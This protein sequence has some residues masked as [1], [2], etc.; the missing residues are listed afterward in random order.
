MRP[1]VNTHL[2]AVAAACTLWGGSLV[3]T[4]LAFDSLSPMA[5]GLIRFSLSTLLFFIILAAR[6]E[7]KVP[8]AAD[9]GLMALT[10]FLGTTLY[11]AAENFG[12][13]ITSAGTASLVVGSFPAM[14]LVLE[15]AVDKKLPRPS[16]AL[17]MG[18]A[19]LGVA[20]LAL[21]GGSVSGGDEAP[22]I[23][24]LMAGGAAWSVYNLLMRRLAGKYSALAITSWQTL[25]GA[26]GF[27]LLAVL[28]G[29]PLQLPSVQS[30]LSLAY[31]VL[32]CTVVGFTLYNYGFEKLSP[33]V[34]S[35]LVNLDPVIGLAL[36]ALVLGEPVSFV[37]LLACAVVVGGIML[38]T[39]E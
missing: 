3:F 33:S 23:T 27:I 25:F 8:K 13:S 26:L 35:S 32:G 28:E 5:L 17:G 38:S 2:L 1:S 4:K 15:C 21:A 22:G 18:L 11:F 29:A 20:A 14:T 9:L 19:F 36:S 37:Q 34:T 30:W 39:R 10:G 7:L 31:L 6:H 12:A 16:T 24:I